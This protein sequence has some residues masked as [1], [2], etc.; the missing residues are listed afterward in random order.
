MRTIVIASLLTAAAAFGPAVG[1]QSTVTFVSA[2]AT[3]PRGCES[4]SP[5][6]VC[7][8][9]GLQRS[10]LTGGFGD[11]RSADANGA[12]VAHL[13]EAA[14]DPDEIA[15]ARPDVASVVARSGALR[16]TRKS[17]AMLPEP[18]TWI[19]MLLG[20]GAIGGL[21]RWRFRRSEARFTEKIRRIEAG[22]TL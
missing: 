1:A 2:P 19:M 18:A 16:A 20:F 14:L 6:A 5:A 17:T 4:R 9:P 15:N 13:D 10:S 3:S 12:L 21:L 22:E 11:A 8:T 7:G